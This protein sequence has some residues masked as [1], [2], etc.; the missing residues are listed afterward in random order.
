M[1]EPRTLPECLKRAAES[2]SGVH[3]V[4]RTGGETFLSYAEIHERALEVAAGLR[5]V[6]ITEGDRI[7][8][9]TPTGPDF[10]DGFFGSVLAGAVPVSLPLPRRFGP[11]DDY[12]R[13]VGAMLGSC[14]ARLVLT[15]ERYRSLLAEIGTELGTWCPRELPRA[16]SVGAAVSPDDLALVQFSSGTT[17]VPKAVAL[18]HAQL[19]AN[20]RAILDVFLS[21]YPE[22]DDFQH[23]GVSWL[24]LYHDMGLV[25]A[26][27]T[28][29][30]RPGPLVLMAPE[31]FIARPARWLQA[32]SRHRASVSAAP[33]FAYALCL[34][35]I[36]DDELDGV[37]LS[38][39]RLA[40]DGAE[41]VT[42]ATLD[43]FFARFRHFGLREEALTPVYGLAEAGLAVTFSDPKHRF[44]AR[45]FGGRTLVSAGKPLPGFDVRIAG[46]GDNGVGRVQ[47]RGPSIMSGY[48]G[49]KAETEHAL[50]EGWLETGDEGFLD[51]G[52]L[53]LT[54]RNRS[55]LVLRGGNY[56]PEI[57]EHA[58]EAIDG[59]HVGSVV[60]TSVVTDRGEELVMLVESRMA[61]PDTARTISATLSERTGFVPH[62]VVLVE[63]G[64]LPRTS[65]GKL[66][67]EE[68]VHRFVAH[69]AVP[70]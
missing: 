47:V 40:L 37:D 14:G 69:S 30:V 44:R 34:E 9:A 50:V 68:A 22:D 51:G 55:K 31:L 16:M 60:A 29:L 13:E 20:V 58:L 67:R 53:F 27:L 63:P 56:A 48:L 15:A 12:L 19:L 3:F 25:G 17:A 32:I 42:P 18:T 11:T 33:H 24:P 61:S 26:V 10:Y 5:R 46:A 62:R 23:R 70:E 21:S 52:E 65:S 28:A 38:S 49:A 66:R 6:G 2:R 35:R 57:F 41:M 45:R 39:W 54:G 59:V 4:E 7:A 36:K 64:T 8:V 1:I 43:R